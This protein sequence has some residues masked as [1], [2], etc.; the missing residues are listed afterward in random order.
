MEGVVLG[1]RM[2]DPEDK[3]TWTLWLRYGNGLEVH[4]PACASKRERTRV[5]HVHRLVY[6]HSGNAYACVDYT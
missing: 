4:V 6:R 3:D 1:V 2:G 5:Q